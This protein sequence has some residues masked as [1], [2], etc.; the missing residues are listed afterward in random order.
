[1]IKGWIREQWLECG[2]DESCDDSIHIH[3]TSPD[4]IVCEA[5]VK[6]NIRIFTTDGVMAQ[7]LEKVGYIDL[8]AELIGRKVRVIIEVIEEVEG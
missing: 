1:M 5:V 4:A 7:K 3:Q 8:P 2:K 6:E